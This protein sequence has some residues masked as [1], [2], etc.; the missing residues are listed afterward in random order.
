M[1]VISII[2]T[3]EKH[4]EEDHDERYECV[5]SRRASQ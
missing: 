4:H 1:D 5:V 3:M 2:Q